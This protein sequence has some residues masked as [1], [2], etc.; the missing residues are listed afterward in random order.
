MPDLTARALWLRN[1]IDDLTIS[2]QSTFVSGS[3]ATRVQEHRP[4]IAARSTDASAAS[5]AFIAFDKGGADIAGAHEAWQYDTGTDT[6]VDQR[7]EFN[8][9]ASGDC[10]PWPA[11]PES[12]DAFYLGFPEPFES[13]SIDVGTAGVSAGSMGVQYW[14]GSSWVG[15]GATDNT[16][17]LKNLGV[18]TITWTSPSAWQKT[19]VNSGASLYFV[20]FTPGTY[21][22]APVIDEGDLVSELLD[23]GNLVACPMFISHDGVPGSLMWRLRFSAN[24]DLSSPTYDSGGGGIRVDHP[25]SGRNFAHALLNPYDDDTTISPSRYGRF[26]FWA[27][28]ATYIDIGRIYLA[29]AFQSALAIQNG[30]AP[31][32]KETPVRLP[33]DRGQNFS[34]I[35]KRFMGVGGSFLSQS[36]EEASKDWNELFAYRGTSQDLVYVHRPSQVAEYL[37]QH[38]VYGRF[39]SLAEIALPRAGDFGY[40]WLFSGVR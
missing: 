36:E 25:S 20:R 26:D 6:Y 4:T 35:G 10:S 8:S 5:P 33:G 15:L 11:S 40:R 38:L 12:G 23:P 13:L 16:N 17:G 2:A 19:D 9:A 39:D 18:N 3:P 32:E 21:T 7:D 34:V 14:N 24:S 22:T 29:K 31:T 28:D 1:V 37:Q 30:T 27:V